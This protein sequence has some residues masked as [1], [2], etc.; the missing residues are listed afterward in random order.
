MN[1]KLLHKKLNYYK[2]VLNIQEI[3]LSYSDKGIS[4]QWIYLNVIYPTYRIGR[5]TFYEYLTENAKGKIKEIE[6]KLATKEV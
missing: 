4:N 1:K 3:Y 6:E 2:R 5:S